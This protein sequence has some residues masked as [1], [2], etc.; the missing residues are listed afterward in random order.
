[1]T[2]MAQKRI[3]KDLRNLEKNPLNEHGIYHLF[4]EDDI[5]NIKI[6]M[7]GPKDTPYHNGF[8]FFDLRFPDN[9][10][11]QPPKVKFCTLDS[12]VRFNPNLYVDGKVCLSIINTWSGPSWTSVQTLS[13]VLL[14]IQS[15]LNEYP[16]RNEPGFEN[17][18]D[19]RC[20]TYNDLITYETSRVAV[21]NM[22]CNIPNTFESF[23]VII[24]NYFIENID[25]YI[26]H[27]DLLSKK[28]EGKIINSP[29]YNMRN[30]CNYIELKKNMIKLY[31][32][33]CPIDLKKNYENII[34]IKKEAILQPEITDK[35]KIKL[36]DIKKIIKTP[37][38]KAVNFPEGYSKLSDRDKSMI[39]TVICDKNGNKKW[40]H[41][42]NMDIKSLNNKDID[43]S[44]KNDVLYL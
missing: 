26:N 2:N 27:L 35:L 16:L 1:M 6:L 33:I 31:N 28:Y 24:K 36:T 13:S 18:T 42:K 41:N 34:D 44:N 29:I 8:F 11:F 12:K 21:Y 40:K 30:K 4:N 32:N 7:V 20:I 22:L 17:E 14:S 43:I 5:Y 15:L 3:I 25:W 39:Y 10:P 38:D 23:L 37:T 19:S 9:Y